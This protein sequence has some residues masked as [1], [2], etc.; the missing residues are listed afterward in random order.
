MAEAAGF[1]AGL[2]TAMQLAFERAKANQQSG[3][4]TNVTADLAP[5]SNPAPIAL[6]AGSGRN[7]S[8][9]GVSAGLPVVGT[10]A[11]APAR[12]SAADIPVGVSAYQPVDKLTPLANRVA[13]IKSKKAQKLATSAEPVQKP[14]ENYQVAEYASNA[15]PDQAAAPLTPTAANVAARR[16]KTPPNQRRRDIVG[17]I[18][19]VTGGDGIAASSALDITGEKADKQPRLRGLFTNRGTM[20]LGYVADLLRTEEGF[21]VRDGEH[22]AELIGNQA[23]GESVR[24]MSDQDEQATAAAEAKRR[25]WVRQQAGELGVRVVGRKFD[26]VENDVFARM[27]AADHAE[28]AALEQAERAAYDAVL[29]DVRA[30]L[31]EQQIE[32][33]IERHQ[34]TP[35]RELATLL[36]AAYL[37]EINKRLAD[38]A[39][40]RELNEEDYRNA[41][42]E[43]SLGETDASAAGEGQASGRASTDDGQVEPDARPDLQL[44]SQSEEDLARKEA[45]AADEAVADKETA[46]RERSA[47]TL[48]AQTPEKSA[49]T[50]AQSG[51]FTP[52]GRASEA[53]VSQPKPEATPDSGAD[54]SRADESATDRHP[55]TWY[56]STLREAFKTQAGAPAGM[57]R[58]G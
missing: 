48:Q 7:V 22:L 3:I 27:E 5:T 50:T 15:G 21:D 53:A 44:E 14:P 10:V 31:D 54:L 16:K 32:D 8:A 25:D 4:P 24:S 23:R 26:D 58:D 11:G 1:N 9:A 57:A 12:S 51:L 29:E 19:R 56:R 2:P 40:P 42:R 43:E 38:A 47:F 37:D 34:N 6:A 41:S 17:A 46:D 55:G 30:A 39:E 33:L 45:R 35:L 20:D 28:R 49:S 13:A 36:D 52:D 18:L